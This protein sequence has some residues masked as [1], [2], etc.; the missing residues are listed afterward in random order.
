MKNLE[1]SDRYSREEAH[2]IFS[3]DT[4][5][6]PQAGTWGLHGIVPVPY[7]DNDYV[8][9]VTYG[10]KQGEHEFDEEITE[11][12]VLSWQ[13]QPG[14][15]FQNKHIRNFINHNELINNIYLFLRTK[16]GVDYQ[17]MGRL[18]YLNHNP[19]REKPVYFEWQLLDWDSLDYDSSIEIT[20]ID[21]S[22]VSTKP[23][24][25]T[26]V[27]PSKPKATSENN[28]IKSFNVRAKPDY[29]KREADNI[30]L[31]RDGELLV[32][33]YEKERLESI[34]KS[35]LADKVQHTSV[36]EGDGAGYDIR[37]FDAEGNPVFI[38]VKTT[39]G[40]S[41][42]PFYMSSNEKAFAKSHIDSFKIYRVY[43]YSEVNNS[44]EFYV[45][46]NEALNKLRFEPTSYRVDVHKQH[47]ERTIN[48][49]SVETISGSLLQPGWSYDN[50]MIVTSRGVFFDNLVGR[51]DQTTGGIP[52]ADWKSLIGKEI[53][54]EEV[55]FI[56]QYPQF[57]WI[58]LL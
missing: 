7:R 47:I 17:Y 10:Q 27:E 16:K 40:S 3:P 1:L 54:L 46:E 42:T 25:L 14:Q 20:K 15:N 2:S 48:I 29:S 8:F 26:K 11:D 49:I 34:G 22:R 45:V 30:K 9:F 43:D 36:E 32:L 37:S 6:T 57:T 19:T 35:E 24:K 44:G 23:N 38:E 52:G 4:V 53:S 21:T 41:S 51:N 50:Q 13:S 5:F 39:K 12:G 58:K 55:K 31:G 28:K 56:S 33:A 18:K